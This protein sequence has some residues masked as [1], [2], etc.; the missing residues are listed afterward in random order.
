[1]VNEPITM[2]TDYMLAIASTIFAIL[3]WRRDVRLWAIAFLFTACG[4]FF[5]GTYH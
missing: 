1:M 5:G 2:A 4:S 3:L